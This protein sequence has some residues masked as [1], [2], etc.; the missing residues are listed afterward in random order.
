L[1]LSSRISGALWNE[2]WRFA[3]IGVDLREESGALRIP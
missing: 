1:D 3:Q 2:S